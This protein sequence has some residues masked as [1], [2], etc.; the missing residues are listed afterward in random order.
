VKVKQVVVMGHPNKP[1]CSAGLSVFP[2]VMGF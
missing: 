2:S 1:H